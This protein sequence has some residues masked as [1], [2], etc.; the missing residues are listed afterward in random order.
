MSKTS[1]NKI[2]KQILNVKKE[3]KEIKADEHNSMYKNSYASLE[4]ILNTVNEALEK[5]NLF[6]TQPIEVVEGKEIL[7]TIIFNETGNS[8]ESSFLI[9]NKNNLTSALSAD[10]SDKSLKESLIKKARKNGDIEDRLSLI[11]RA[12]KISILTL[13]GIPVIGDIDNSNS[14][15]NS[16]YGSNNNSYVS[17]NTNTNDNS[18]H[19]KRLYAIG[20]AYYEVTNS[21]FDNK[22]FHQKAKDYLSVVLKTKV[23]S[24]NDVKP[25]LIKQYADALE[26]KTKQFKFGGSTK[27]NVEALKMHDDIE[28]ALK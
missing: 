7:K 22:E 17:G 26:E 24:L 2:Y 16:N 3:L 19:I 12:R 23:N 15:S 25:S 1:L 14:N 28:D 18:K 10:I 11:T 21:K 27:E 13:L 8:I 6:L 9:E 5:E 4:G 20:R